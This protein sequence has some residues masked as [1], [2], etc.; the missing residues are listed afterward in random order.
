MSALGKTGIALVAL[1]TLIIIVPSVAVAQSGDI[2]E[3]DDWGD[4]VFNYSGE[5]YDPGDLEAA[6]IN[7][8]EADETVQFRVNFTD[9]A[10]KNPMSDNVTHIYIDSDL[11][12]DTGVN[13]E[14]YTDG[15]DG[16]VFYNNTDDIGADYRV[17]IGD[18]SN[19]VA[20]WNEELGGFETSS[21]E[22]IDVVTRTDSVIAEVDQS[23]IEEEPT[24]TFDLKFVY[25]DKSGTVQDDSDYTWAPDALD[26]EINST[27]F[28]IGDDGTVPVATIEANVNLSSDDYL[29]DEASVEFTLEGEEITETETIEG[30]NHQGSD[31]VTATFNI[32][33]NEFNGG[34]ESITAQVV[35]GVNYTL[36][37][38]KS[39]GSLS[40][41]DKVT[42]NFDTHDLIDVT[43]NVTNLGNED[44]NIEVTLE[45][46]NQDIVDTPI[47]VDPDGD[48]E[49]EFTDVNATRFNDGGALKAELDPASSNTLNPQEISIN[50]GRYNAS[51]KDGNDF[52]VVVPD[53]VIDLAFNESTVDVRTDDPFNLTVNLTSNNGDDTIHGVT[54]VVEFDPTQV[55][56][57]SITPLVVSD[58][59]SSNIT[60]TTNGEVTVELTSSS[61]SELVK[62]DG[63]QDLYNITFE[64]DQE[65]D[66]VYNTDQVISMST[67]DR[68][69][70][71]NDSR[72]DAVPFETEEDAGGETIQVANTETEIIDPT[73]SITHLTTGG[74]MVSAPTKF[75]F[76]VET[77]EGTLDNVTLYNN[78]TGTAV[79]TYNCEGGSTCADELVH[80]A[81]T[82]NTKS[83]NGSY[84]S[85]SNRYNITIY[86]EGNGEVTTIS[87]PR[88]PGEV[89]YVE[90]DVTGD[91]NV[92]LDDVDA[93]LQNTGQQAD[94]GL[95]WGDPVNAR[96]D[97]NNDGEVDIQDATAVAQDW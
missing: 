92:T 24:D 78:R 80:D 36:N 22:G 68:T 75:A 79:D 37:R 7:Y 17:E 3:P 12:S 82:E 91:G 15:D 11:D 5:G 9:G 51:D 94:G 30:E 26:N 4:E 23:T 48:G 47:D 20:P 55:S 28:S 72:D 45:D 25:I 63:G 54:H 31:N 81:P 27:R 41:D 34:D 77:N 53:Q 1:F 19:L 89:I 14:T 18:G 97:V 46:D 8:N 44:N 86:P 96:Y 35:N 90:S 42:K 65:F 85:T 57:K 43:G 69:E 74:D 6:F 64:F 83:A 16:E 39:I 73:D 88:G 59:L 70:L 13:S 40:D 76:D 29:D 49:Y 61:G 32:D 84:D 10:P 67:T 33:A 50:T 95:P 71:I 21:A 58:D 2:N 66:P 93:I 56:V 52:D 62:K 38:E 87:E 60:D